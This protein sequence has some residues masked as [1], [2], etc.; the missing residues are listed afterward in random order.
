MREKLQSAFETLR[1]NSASV[2]ALCSMAQDS[3]IL[4]EEGAVTLHEGERVIPERFEDEKEFVT[5]PLEIGGEITIHIDRPNF[6]S[7]AN[8]KLDRLLEEY[9]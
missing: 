7:A 2:E 8:A 6:K 4:V 9:E 5:I 3:G 1:D